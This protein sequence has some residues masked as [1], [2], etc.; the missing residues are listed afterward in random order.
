MRGFKNSI[1]WLCSGELHDRQTGKFIRHVE[2]EIH[3]TDTE[4]AVNSF[5]M[6][7][8][9]QGYYSQHIIPNVTLRAADEGGA[10]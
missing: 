3:Q 6:A 5:L 8:D 2:K 4:F 9:A 10:K 7:F 1:V